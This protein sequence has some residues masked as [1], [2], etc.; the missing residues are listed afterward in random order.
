MRFREWVSVRASAE[1]IKVISNS[2]LVAAYPRQFGRDK[3]VSDPWHYLYVLEEKPGV[4]RNS[5]P[6]K[7]RDLPVSLH[8]VR[9]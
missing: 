2:H 5:A 9:T 6:F 1:R 8:K 3:V 7:E 4:L